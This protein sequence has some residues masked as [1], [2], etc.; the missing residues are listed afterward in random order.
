MNDA[1]AAIQAH[2]ELLTQLR[3]QRKFRD[4]TRKVANI[5][6]WRPNP[7][8]SVGDVLEQRASNSEVF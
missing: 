7:L 3:A 8:L 4:Y 2:R 1:T 5:A 6:A